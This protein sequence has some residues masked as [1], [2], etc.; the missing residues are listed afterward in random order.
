MQKHLP[1]SILH[2]Q[3]LPPL[4]H[5]GHPVYPLGL[6]RADPGAEQHLVRWW[7]RLHGDCPLR[8]GV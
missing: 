5:S 3:V 2:L 4:D 7:A 6:L 1:L 8:D